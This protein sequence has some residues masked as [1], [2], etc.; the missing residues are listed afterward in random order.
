MRETTYIQRK[1]SRMK[2]RTRSQETQSLLLFLLLLF[3]VE[4]QVFLG[5]ES[6]KERKR[7]TRREGSSSSEAGGQRKRRARKP[8]ER[9]TRRS[10]LKLKARE[11]SLKKN[12]RRKKLRKNECKG[13][14][15]YNFCSFSYFTSVTSRHS[16]LCILHPVLPEG[17]ETLLMI[18]LL[19]PS[20]RRSWD[21][22]HLF[23]Y[24]LTCGWHSLAN[25]CC[26]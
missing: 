13:M 5:G 19:L 15:E 23:R 20:M 11:S 24:F 3:P 10:R 26:Y 16:F 17:G 12:V 18:F 6:L 1:K 25:F 7:T 22:S 21:D 4:Q 9:T 8:G 14:S 2:W